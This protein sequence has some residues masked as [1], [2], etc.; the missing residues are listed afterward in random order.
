MK[1]L[2]PA[3]SPT[4]QREPVKASRLRKERLLKGLRQTDLAVL[5]DVSHSSVSLCERAPRLL[6]PKMAA[7]LAA[8]LGVTADD[9]LHGEG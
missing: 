8:V 3:V 4:L 9:L 1:R 7:K 6:R 2:E 5:A